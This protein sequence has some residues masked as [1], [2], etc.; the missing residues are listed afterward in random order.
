[1]SKPLNK[2]KRVQPVIKVRQAKVEVEAATLTLIRSEKIAVVAEMR[3]NQRKYI[4]GIDQLNTQRASLTR[5]LLAPL[6]DGLDYIKAKWFKLHRQVQ[7]LEHKEKV[8][9]ANLLAAQRDL[10]AIEKL[11]ENYKGQFATEMRKNEQKSIDEV[12][13]RR[14]NNPQ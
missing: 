10:K 3:E 13:I 12:A 6:E 8:Q 2:I 9:L 11:E 4:E 1:M 5:E 14:Y 7:D